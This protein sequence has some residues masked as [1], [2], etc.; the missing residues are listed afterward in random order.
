[1]VDFKYKKSPVMRSYNPIP[2]L[3]KDAVK[4]ASKLI[5][6]AK[7]PLILAG[8]GIQIANAHDEFKKFVEK[9]GIP[10][11]ATIHGL[12]TIPSDHPLFVGMLGMHGNYSP[13]ILTN[14]ADLIIAIGMRFDDR[15]TGNLKKYESKAKVIH[16]DIDSSEFNKNVTVDVKVHADAKDAIVTLHKLCKKKVYSS[17]FKKFKNL[18]KLELKKVIKPELRKTKEG[19]LKMARVVREVSDQTDGK[20][21]V[22]TDVG[23][24]QMIAARYYEYKDKNLW[25]SSGGAGTMGFGLPAG[26]KNMF[27]NS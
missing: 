2:T 23:Q 6:E 11:A 7:K 27:H 15:V 20:A 8:H 13:N 18:D 17:W 9:T 21:I 14:K 4:S 25:I 24:H 16:I 10:V 26:R 1:M 3:D 12:S 19:V 5:S 22:V